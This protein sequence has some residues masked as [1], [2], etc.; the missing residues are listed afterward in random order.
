MLP[1]AVK[2][3]AM[4]LPLSQ[5]QVGKAAA[6]LM[7]NFGDAIHAAVKGK[8]Y[9]AALACAIAAKETGAYWVSRIG[10]LSPAEILGLQVGDAS[11]DV[12]G[13]SRAAFPRNT[14]EFRARYGDAFTDMLIAEANKARALRGFSPKAWVYKGYGIFQYDLQ[15]V[16]TDEDF[17]RQKQWY[18]MAPCLARMTRVLD[19]TV[20][21]AN[22]I[23]R[24]AVRR[25]NG[26]GPAAEEYAAHVMT[27]VGWCRR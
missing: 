6:W 20:T 1:A 8:P 19:R 23:E 27:F 10:K 9:D 25:Y 21:R 5:D 2:E 4:A 18:E 7:A 17:F 24:D 3:D 12:P 14:A 16:E 15:H 11:G 26:T 22:G 13:T